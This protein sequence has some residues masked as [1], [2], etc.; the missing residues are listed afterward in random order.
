MR[1][2]S[3]NI[4]SYLN[5][6]NCYHLVRDK[7]ISG[8]S[9]TGIVAEVCQFQN[10]WCA[11]AFLPHTAGVSNV[12]VYGNIEDVLKIHGHSGSTRLVPIYKYET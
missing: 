8:V 1:K 3:K 5:N 10:G 9:G 7:D 12:I 4:I 6:M 11:L 2:I